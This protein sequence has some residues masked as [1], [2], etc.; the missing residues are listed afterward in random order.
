VS[1]AATQLSRLFSLFLTEGE[2]GGGKEEEQGVKHSDLHNLS[3][4]YGLLVRE[5]T[6]SQKLCEELSHEASWKPSLF[7]PM[8]FGACAGVLCLSL[9]HYFFI[10][11][12]RYGRHFETNEINACLRTHLGISTLCCYSL[13][14]FTI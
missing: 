10:A 4:A 13:V 9:I 2:E 1:L 14:D 12:P 8:K 6:C 7:L 3:I 5:T 11:P